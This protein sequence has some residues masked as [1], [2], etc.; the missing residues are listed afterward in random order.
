MNLSDPF[1]LSL[2][3]DYLFCR[4]RTGLKAIEGWRGT[5]VTCTAKKGQNRCSTL[6]L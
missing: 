4:R 2:L 1:P 6:P 3:N 5:N